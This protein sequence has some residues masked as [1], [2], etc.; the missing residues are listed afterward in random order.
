[1]NT[2]TTV[3]INTD[4]HIVKTELY[5]P[6]VMDV[7]LRDTTHFSKR[8]LGNLSRYKRGRKHGNE[9]EVV[10]HFGRGCEQNQLGRLYPRNGQGLQ[11]FNFD[12]RNP[13]LEKHYWDCDME[14]CH[15]NILWKLADTWGLKTDAIQQYI[16]NREA[17]LRKVSSNRTIAKTA[18]LKV[19]YGGNIKLYSDYY[20]DGIDPE[21]DITLLKKIESELKVIVDNCWIRHE[22]YQKIVKRKDNP[23]FSLFALIL[24]TEERKCLLAIDDY[25]KSKG[26][27]ID[28]YIHDGGEVRK[29]PNETEFPRNLLIEASDHI[30]ELYGY[31]MRLVIK[32][33]QH[34][35]K[36]PISETSY[37][38][39]REEFERTHFKLMNPPAY[40]CVIDKQLQLLTKTELNLK[41]ENMFFDE[42]STFISKWVV[43]PEMRTY[44]TIVF[45]PM[46]EIDSRSFNLFQ[47]FP[48]EAIKGDI[49][50]VH[51]VLNLISNNDSVVFNY[52]ERL[53]AWIIQKPYQKTGVC[54]IIQSSEEGS[55]KDTYFD[56]IGRILGEYF[57][58]TCSAEDTIFSRF[59]GC[60]KQ[61]LLVKM[62]ELNFLETKRYAD[63]FKTIITAPRI[64]FEDKGKGSLTLDNFTTFVGTTNNDVPVVVSD[65][66]RRFA[67]F[68]ASPERVGDHQ[69]WNIIQPILHSQETS[70]AYFHHLL[71][72]D[73][74]DFKPREFPKSDY[75]NEVKEAFIPYS[76][77]FFQNI[78]EERP[79]IEV[80]SWKA[81]ELIDL[82]KGSDKFE[83]S[84][85][86]IGRHLREY[87]DANIIKKV[88]TKTGKN[89]S[90]ETE[91]M[92]NYLIQ[93][94]WW[95]EL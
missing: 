28:I 59:N 67:L 75:Y 63:K 74:T 34:S 39:I 31:N 8:D 50:A 92:K 22:Q 20:S 45:S 57:M 21:G 16:R 23:K 19:A 52:I 4:Y 44:D 61:K 58:N 38:S 91:Q 3:V 90:I 71:N 15:Y 80:Y 72:L 37:E 81:N 18:F 25:F 26:R 88:H 35:F 85:T 70:E 46:K 69:F 76:A 29:L 36:M 65:T 11:S 2:E 42:T 55:G 10:Y 56:L 95:Y 79:E 49:S 32:P 64:T 17:E 87:I 77:R 13:L 30:R 7:L 6:D 78:I 5:D 9:V 62:E 93:K 82:L 83:R 33:F 60:W 41:Y 43:D 12:M 48:T 51:Q 24:Q 89:Y 66:A 84:T 53:M 68:K 54:L 94:K 47:G 1:M 73:L 27:Q 40:V 86:A 14:N